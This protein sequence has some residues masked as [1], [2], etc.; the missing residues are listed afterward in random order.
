VAEKE[1]L[2]HSHTPSKKD[3]QLQLKAAKKYKA[4]LEKRLHE[5]NVRSVQE[6]YMVPQSLV[7]AEMRKANAMRER[8]VTAIERTEE[9]DNQVNDLGE[10]L[11]ENGDA[12]R[13]QDKAYRAMAA[14]LA[15]AQWQLDLMF[16]GGGVLANLLVAD[17]KVTL[18]LGVL[19]PGA[20]LPPTPAA[21]PPPKP[22]PAAKAKATPAPAVAQAAPPI[23][24]GALAEGSA[25]G[26]APP[27]SCR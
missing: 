4:A 16:C 5:A 8:L 11:T 22:E 23:E 6:P 7:A 10:V 1:A 3:L 26:A 20:A 9:L 12:L 15:Y 18:S 27:P 2:T 25:Q 19:M 13:A 14:Q 21:E 17:G 24:G